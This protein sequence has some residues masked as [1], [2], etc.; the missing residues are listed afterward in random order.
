[1]TNWREERRQIATIARATFG[2]F[3][4]SDLM[5][6]GMQAQSAIWA[7]AFFAAPALL[8]C[9]Q[10]LV[11]YNFIR[12]YHPALVE[13]SLWN[14]QA[15]FILLSAGAIGIVS[16]VTWDTLFPGRRDVFVLGPLPV[17]TRVQSAGRLGG[18][19]TL[20]IL[21]ALALNML[22]AVLFPV[23]SAGSILAIGR[24]IAGHFTTTLAADAF[25]FFGMTAVQGTLIVL[26]SRR[27]AER[28]APV[29]QTCT[30][31]ALL[32]T[33]LFFAPL[34]EATRGALER[35][36]P[37][38][39]ILRWFPLAW[40]VGLYGVIAGT[41][42][43]IMQTLALRGLLAGTL[44]LV[45]T[46]ALYLCAYRWLC[47]RAIESPARSTTSSFSRGAAA[48]MKTLLVRKPT[49]QAVCSFTLRALARS[50]RHRMLLSI[51][52]G[53]ALALICAAL[54]PEV[55]G[56]RS[57]RFAHPSVATLAAPLIL[58]VGLAVG[59]RVLLAI[60]VDVPARWIFELVHLTPLRAAGGVHKAG[61]VVVLLPV[62]VSA[63]LSAALLWGPSI[64]WRHVLFCTVLSTL[65]LE[66]LLVNYRGVPFSRVYVPGGS[67]FHL[68]WPL[69]LTCFITYTYSAAAV[70]REMLAN[71]DL[72]GFLIVFSILTM[73]VTVIRVWGVSRASPLSF[74]V[75]IP[76]ATFAGFNLSEGLAA[77]AVGRHEPVAPLRID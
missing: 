38:D 67:R 29:I 41:S 62:A 61:M 2:G 44:P 37:G 17:A 66:L 12:R 1:M 55:A 11:K 49:E 52:I 7:A 14:D 4:Q 60:P 39:P 25:V 75:E 34:R 10:D 65:L 19:L 68:L 57:E 35:G 36:D 63:W 27:A 73:V 31:L 22:P 51:Y 6:A 45:A 16:V 72:S 28:L 50:R 47:A 9:A 33:L 69:Y 8:P 5:P 24:N 71:R 21:F 76:D 59:F 70:E 15:L 64:A 13:P 58:S 46:A 54:L 53:G 32:L 18:L 23:V 77:Q 20:F 3:L 26:T 42:R 74:A 40:F 56:V 30:V 48:M 43:P